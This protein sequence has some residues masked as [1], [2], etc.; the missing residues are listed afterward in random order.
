MVRIVSWNVNGLRSLK[1]SLKTV[2]DSLQADI[3]CLQE[4]RIS[5]SDNDLEKLALVPGYDSFFSFC[6]VRQGYSGVA[7]FTRNG[8]KHCAGGSNLC[9]TPNDAG[10]GLTNGVGGVASNLLP[11]YEGKVS[12]VAE[13]TIWI[14]VVVSANDYELMRSEGRVVITDHDRFVLIN[15]YLPAVSVDGRA[16]FKLAVCRAL[17]LKVHALREAGRHVVIAGDFNISPARCDVAEPVLDA[18]SFNGR[19]SRRWLRNVMLGELGFKDSFRE[20]HP[21]SNSAFTCWSEATR[22]RE[23]NF[24]AR[25]DL[26]L[27]DGDLFNADVVAAD[28]HNSIQ[29]SDHC[30]ISIEMRDE[31]F[32]VGRAVRA[33]PPFCARYLA[34]FAAKQLT[35]SEM[36]SRSS[37]AVQPSLDSSHRLARGQPSKQVKESLQPED[38][39]AVE[40]EQRMGG[41]SEATGGASPIRA[42]EEL[43]PFKRARETSLSTSNPRKARQIPIKTYFRPMPDDQPKSKLE[44]GNTFTSNQHEKEVTTSTV[45]SI[46]ENDNGECAVP[47]DP[48][49]LNCGSKDS[50]LAWK[51]LLSGPPAPPLCRHGE[52]CKLKG[53]KKSGENKGRTF[54]GC[55]RPAGDWPRDKNANCNYFKWAPYRAGGTMFQ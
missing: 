14:P 18:A 6:T 36:F 7:T 37:A 45:V 24:G 16:K 35:I 38:K 52:P 23:N 26:I 43:R 50:A 1:P 4:T 32:E 2:F 20:L 5:E 49:Q 54:Y 11:V 31:N 34:R 22:A 53:V 9:L 29:G 10:E 19:P 3:I 44:F 30:P 25:I 12:D 15:V 55:A 39:L 51:Q 17:E 33:P 28:V 48:K 40:I 8:S 13:E 21:G 46:L 27:V 42:R 41:N 47:V